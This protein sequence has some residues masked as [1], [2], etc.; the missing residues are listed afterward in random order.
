MAL[1]TTLPPQGATVSFAALGY[2]A[3][4]LTFS[5]LDGAEVTA[6]DVTHLGT[7]GA[8]QFKP[9][10]LVNYGTMTMTVQFDGRR[11]TMGTADTITITYDAGTSPNPT[12]VGTGFVSGFSV[13]STQGDDGESEATLTITWDGDTPPAFSA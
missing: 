4:V 10:K 6:K 3:K 5:P 2:T 12:V 13:D 7:T 11:P 9:G 8:R 1:P